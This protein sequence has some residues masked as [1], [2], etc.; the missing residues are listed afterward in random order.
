MRNR[1]N[2]LFFCALMMVGTGFVS[3][4]EDDLGPSIFDTND[5]PLDKTKYSFPLDTFLKV[6]FLEP[7][8]VKF[9]Y[10]M[11]D[12]GSDM[13][14][15]LTPAIRRACNWPCW[16]NTSGMTYTRSTVPTGS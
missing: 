6:S 3:C 4:S 8:N 5:Y 2:I 13:Q 14:K 7:Y 10:R 12:I 11:E 16:R 1:L 9:I 15:N